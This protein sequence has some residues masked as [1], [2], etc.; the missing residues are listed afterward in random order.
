MANNEV[1]I[2]VKSRNE[3]KGGL[4]EASEEVNKLGDKVKEMGKRT[5]EFIAANVIEAG[6]EKV[7]EFVGDSVEAYSNL[8]ES[9]NA[10][11]KIFGTSQNVIL[12]WGKTT[13]NSY[14]LSQRAFNDLA[15]PLGAGLKN[16]GIPLKNTADLTIEL[17]KRASDMAS[18][19]NTSVPEA[20]DAIQSGLRGESDPLERYGVGLTAAKVQ[21]EALAE[22]GKKT[23]ASL[24]PQQLAM[25]RI[26]LI[27]KQTSSTQGDFVQTSGQLANAQ[28]IASAKTEEL[29]AKIGQQLQP[30]VLAVTKAKLA[31]TA[32][33]SDKLLPAM[34]TLGTWVEKNST[35]MELTAAIVG[36]MLV[37][38]FT[39]WAIAAGAAAIATLVAMAPLLAI[40]AAIGLVAFAFIKAADPTSK[41]GGVV[42]DV[43]SI[44][45]GAILVAA[46]GI[47]H[48]LKFIVMAFLDAGGLISEGM[49][50]ALGWVPGLGPKLDKANAAFQDF[51]NGV[52]GTFDSAI[53]KVDQ[54]RDQVDKMPKEV[55]LE[56]NIKDLQS[57]IDAAKAKLKTVPASKR[58]AIQAN[59][60]N[61]Q[62]QVDA[63]KRKLNELKNKYVNIFTTAY[64][65]EQFRAGR[66]V[67]VPGMAHGGITGAASGGPR[68]GWTLVGEA[69][70]ELARLPYGTSVI[71]SGQS[72][73]MLGAG[74]GGASTVVLEIHSGGSALDDVLVQILR[75]AIR[76]R[77]GNVQVVLGR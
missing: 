18:V 67:N 3:S 40:G 65:T 4:R 63:A 30:A 16:A 48:M 58:A 21:A 68:D 69:G 15:V 54:W 37:A 31:L 9:L 28:R 39:S 76:V 1:E 14:G 70:P 11:N 24:T 72:K 34:I 13:A 35:L 56:G 47:L 55:K 10:V 25:A 53:N 42:R 19:F 60:T 64:V 57:K 77:G 73:A 29:Q 38:A 17:T 44:A 74:G 36:G 41:F 51:K 23:A 71:P 2:V 50:K 7:K 33:I 59:I 75:K 45:A 22:T 49:D 12:N 8:N 6:A 62:H 46:D 43:M 32:A 52:S 66:G 20:L 61:L 26:N 5:A 27:M